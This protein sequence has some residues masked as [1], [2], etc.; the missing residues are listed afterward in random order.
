MSRAMHS[1]TET[2]AQRLAANPTEARA[3]AHEVGIPEGGRFA[4]PTARSAEGTRPPVDQQ[5][6]KGRAARPEVFTC[7]KVRSACRTL[8][9]GAADRNRNGEHYLHLN[10][11][12][13]MYLV[14]CVE[15]DRNRMRKAIKKGLALEA[16]MRTSNSLWEQLQ[17]IR[18]QRQFGRRS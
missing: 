7:E 18:A 2:A 11:S 9:D 16:D 1:A 15:G 13:F 6:P 5:A 3:G 17:I 8:S 14:S 4:H 10:D 12:E